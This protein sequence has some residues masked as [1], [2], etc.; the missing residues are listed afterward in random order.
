MTGKLKH[1]AQY[2]DA[3]VC[4][5]LE[6]LDGVHGT[7]IDPFAGPGQALPRFEA[8]RRRVIGYEIEQPWAD[9]SKLVQQG[10]ATHLP[11][12]AGAIAAVFTSV[13]YGNRFSDHHRARD[14]S[15][16]RGYTH[17]IR[18]QTGDPDYELHERNTGKTR[19]DSAEYKKLHRA[20][21]VEFFRVLRR[22]SKKREGGMLLLNV[23][24]FIEHGQ[25]VDAVLWHLSV[26]IR[27]GFEW[28]AAERIVTPRMRHGA[29][30]DA[31]VDGEWLLE[32]RR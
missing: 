5:M 31:R 22:P 11:A 26:C 10:D 24:N 13:V 4:A 14:Q 3:I 9:C 25:V 16:R 20:A 29:N 8:P 2:S 21:Y 18:E 6:R 17:D 15:R 30:H 27:I 12:K 1:P 32:F 7:I 23:S 28:R 19:F